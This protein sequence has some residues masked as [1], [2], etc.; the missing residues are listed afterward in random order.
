MARDLVANAEPKIEAEH[1]I[2]KPEWIMTT[3][4]LTVPLTGTCPQDLLIKI[5]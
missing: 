1:D 2:S 4:K 5:S 3:K